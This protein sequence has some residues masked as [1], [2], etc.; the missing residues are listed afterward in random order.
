MRLGEVLGLTWQDI[1]FAKKRINLWRQINRLNGKGYYFGTLKTKSSKRYILIDDYLLGELT[2]WRSQQNENEKQFGD[3]YVY[4]YREDDGHIL[5]QSKGLPAPAA[6]KVSLICVREDGRLIVSSRFMALLKREGLNAHSF[7]H[8]HTTQLIENGASAKDVAE[9]LG[10][11]DATITQNLYTH[12]TQK[13]QEET[14]A[15]FV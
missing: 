8:T 14:I 13:L 12:N 1:D 9:R 4:I 15:V 11:A 7:R 3:S 2:S 5:R 10:H 6:E